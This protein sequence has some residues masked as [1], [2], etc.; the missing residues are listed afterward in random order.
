MS[1][2]TGNVVLKAQE[3]IPDVPA[4]YVASALALMCGAIVFF[5]GLVRIGWIVEFISLTAVSAFIT[6]SAFFIAIGQVPALLGISKDYVDSRAATYKVVITTLQNLEHCKL[7][8]AIGLTG[9]FMLYAIKYGM[10]FAAK[11]APGRA[12]LL[13]FI[14][15][16]R[17][18][19]VILLYTLISWLVNRHRRAEDDRAFKTLGT[20]PRGRGISATPMVGR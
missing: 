4:H 9:L 2:V 17:T 6:G 16:L 8:A 14:N 18:V 5:M 12:R 19:F 11:K 10:A 7:D 13:F 20:V 1:T 3:D 15:T